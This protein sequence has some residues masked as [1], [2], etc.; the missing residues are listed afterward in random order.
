MRIKDI[1]EPREEVIKGNLEPTVQTHKV[2]SEEER[3]ESDPEKFLDSTYPSN[4]IRN[5][6][7]QV[8]NK[9]T[10]RENQGGIL[11]LGPYGSGKSHALITLYHLFNSPSLAKE[12][13]KYWNI[14]FKEVDNSQS[15]ILSTQQEDPDKLWVPL[16][17]K[18]GRKDL[19]DE[20]SR[21]PTT[22]T[23]EKLV[24]E[25]VFAIFLD[26]I[27][28][29]WESF[30]KDDDKNIMEQ[31]QFFLQNLLEVA[32]DKNRQLF[33][34]ITLLDKSVDLKEIINRT[35]P[36]SEDVSSSGD[37]EKI[38]KHRLLDKPEDNLDEEKAKEVVKDYVDAYSKPI[39]IKNIKR[40]ESEF[41][42]SYPFHPTLLSVL[43]DIYEGARERQ[44]VRGEMRVLADMVKNLYDETDAFL[45]SDVNHKPFRN[46]RRILVNKFETDVQKRI[47]DIDYGEKILKT[48]LLYS[49][50]SETGA[51]TESDILIN[52]FKPSLGMKIN[53]LSMSLSNL[54]GKAHYLHKEDGHYRIKEERNIFALI[55]GEKK[56]INDEDALERLAEIIKKDI[57]DNRVFI[58]EKEDV[59]DDRNV[60]FVVS[61]ES[62]GPEESINDELEDFYYGRNYQ[63]TI[64][65]IT[66][67]NGGPAND[68]TILDKVKR[69]I[70]ADNLADR[71]DEKSPEIM[72]ILREEKKEAVNEIKKLYGYRVKWSAEREGHEVTPIKKQIS[73]DINAIKEDI[74]TD[75]SLLR[76]A[77]WEQVKDKEEG[78]RVE[79]ILSDFKKFRK[80]PLVSD[81]NRFYNAVK[82]MN[83]ERIYIEGDR[84]K[85]Y[86]EKDPEKIKDEYVI[87]DMKFGPEEKSISEEAEEKKQ[88]TLTGEVPEV[89]DEES[90]EVEPISIDAE[91]NSPR[92]I[93]TR[94]EMQLNENTDVVNSLHIDLELGE[95][96]KEQLLKIIDSLPEADKIQA[97]IE[98]EKRESKE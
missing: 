63:N 79:E 77:I 50:D 7:D 39:E 30:D 52:S 23:I 9:L 83:R 68:R 92:V 49:L 53:Q 2:D 69:I 70:A 37:R 28:S 15:I 65:F 73:P 17:K 22:E 75:K 71:I 58:Y 42:E 90:Y 40:F 87:L 38:I 27:E 13:A 25:D 16:F 78:K 98:G 4:S 48:I 3:I 94:Y 64:V 32:K 1:I 95:I 89:E 56:E 66:P 97:R 26:E 14:D 81:D 72:N 41:L 5:I 31:N 44:S 55:Q 11:L 8:N 80:H 60:T 82:N 96:N 43:G 46:I 93:K 67:K 34:L 20:V 76:E 10:F 84:S 45:L 54:I 91:G 19:L 88:E 35:Q 59:P 61:M 29:W 85:I 86:T 21:Y 47:D 36:F 74:K 6:I 12:W 18:A 57:F 24:G 51:A 33:V 62:I